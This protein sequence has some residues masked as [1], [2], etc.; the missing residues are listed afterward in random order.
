MKHAPTLVIPGFVN[1]GVAAAQQAP[2]MIVS[3]NIEDQILRSVVRAFFP[4]HSPIGLVDSI[5]AHP[6]VPDGLT[7]MAGEILLPGF[8]VADLVALRKT[9][10][11]SVD[12][13]FLPRVDKRGSSSVGLNRGQGRAA[14]HAV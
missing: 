11:V 2:N 3:P 1:E 7:Q 10:A 8:G 9:V 5:A 13:A 4:N 6:E 14:V 12:A